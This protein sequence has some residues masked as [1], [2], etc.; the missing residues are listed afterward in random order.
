MGVFESATQ[1][2]GK[3]AV[4]HAGTAD[5]IRLD[6]ICLCQ[7]EDRTCTRRPAGTDARL[8]ELNL[9]RR[10]R[11]QP[12][13][14]SDLFGRGLAQLA[15]VAKK[16]VDDLKFVEAFVDQVVVECLHERRRP[17]QEHLRRRIGHQGLQQ[18]GG[19]VAGTVVIFA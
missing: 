10:L 17:A 6:P 12:R 18:L 11:R 7:F 16:F 14:G 1:H 15:G 4:A 13:I 9:E 8:A 3:A 2:N 19:D 5:E